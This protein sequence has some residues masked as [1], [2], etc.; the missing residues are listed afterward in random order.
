MALGLI[1]Q[2]TVSAQEA[3]EIWGIV[4][5]PYELT[6]RSDGFVIRH[7]P[8]NACLPGIFQKKDDALKVLANL[9]L[10][11]IQP[12]DG[13][14]TY[15]NQPMTLCDPLEPSFLPPRPVPY[16]TVGDDAIGYAVLKQI[17]YYPGFEPV[18][19]SL[20]NEVRNLEVAWEHDTQE[21]RTYTQDRSSDI[22]ALAAQLRLDA[23]NQFAHELSEGVN[24]EIADLRS[25]YPELSQ[26]SDG[27]LYALF[28]SYQ[29]E[30]CY[31]G[32]WEANRDDGFLFYLIGRLAGRQCAQD[33]AEEVGRWAAYAMLQGDTLDTALS[34]GRAAAAY[35]IAIFSLARRIADA[36][37]FLAEG[38]KATELRGR[39]IITMMDWFRFGRKTNNKPT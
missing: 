26:L 35:G 17:V 18:S 5:E 2:S 37:C 14:F 3:V 10:G 1:Q 30:C 39:P 29:S 22:W 36:M 13:S 12:G 25:L 9:L 32:G 20:F 7:R 38:N 21:I 27:S 33:T 11:G 34:T 19:E 16:R 23:L 28:D 4:P 6:E 15:R 8:F 24:Q 31:I